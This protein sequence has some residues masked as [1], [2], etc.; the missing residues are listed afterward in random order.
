[1][2]FIPMREHKGGRGQDEHRETDSFGD[3]L[4]Y[5]LSLLIVTPVTSRNILALQ[6]GAQRDELLYL[7]VQV[8]SAQFPMW[9][10]S[11]LR[12]SSG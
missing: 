7:Q 6:E 5:L 8:L 11:H 9:R 10:R 1:M 2:P 12:Q 4:L 3:V